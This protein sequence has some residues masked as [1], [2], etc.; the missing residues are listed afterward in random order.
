M[1]FSKFEYMVLIG[2]IALLRAIASPKSGIAIANAMDVARE[3]RRELN[4]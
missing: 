2:L 3:I 4:D 1:K